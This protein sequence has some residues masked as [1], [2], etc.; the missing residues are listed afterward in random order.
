[1]VEIT[2]AVNIAIESIRPYL[3]EVKQNGNN[4]EVSFNIGHVKLDVT[5]DKDD[6]STITKISITGE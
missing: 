1:M 4:W 3:N 5:V 2:E 6:G